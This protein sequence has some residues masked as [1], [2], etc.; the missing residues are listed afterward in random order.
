[1]RA[2]TARLPK[3][4]ARGRRSKAARVPPSVERLVETATAMFNRFGIHATG[5]DRILTESG[6]A[7]MTLYNHFGS[8]D[9]L[10]RE[11]LQRESVA[12]FERLDRAMAAAGPTAWDRVSVYFDV[13]HAWSSQADFKGCGFMNAVGESSR[14][15]DRVRPIARAHRDANVAYVRR[16]LDPAAPDADGLAD[17]IV[18]IADGATVGVMVT[19]DLG[20]VERARRIAMGLLDAPVSGPR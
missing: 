6:V 18:M 13:L 19:D 17:T 4:P 2:F 9:G 1:M 7:R 20:L 5:I 15:D 11:V 16:L 8:K 12:W 10:V 14:D 3:T